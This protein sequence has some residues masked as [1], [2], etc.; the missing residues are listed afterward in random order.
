MEQRGGGMGYLARV[1]LDRRAEQELGRGPG[2]GLA[3]SLWKE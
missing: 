1:V 2:G 3:A